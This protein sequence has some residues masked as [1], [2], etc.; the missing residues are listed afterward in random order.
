MAEAVG[1]RSLSGNILNGGPVDGGQP[2]QRN[3]RNTARLSLSLAILNAVTVWRSDKIKNNYMVIKGGVRVAAEIAFAFTA[4]LGII[5]CVARALF[6][7][8]GGLF[9]RKNIFYNGFTSAKVA[10]A[11]I[12]ASMYYALQNINLCG[13]PNIAEVEPYKRDNGCVRL[14]TREEI[15]AMETESIRKIEEWA[16]NRASELAAR[17]A[18]FGIQNLSQEEQA[19]LGGYR[20][21]HGR[22]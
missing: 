1:Q 16:D 7:L 14:F 21:E 20:R 10:F 8:A 13:S 6:G 22:V 18:Q 9:C 2:P 15:D 19:F 17:E 11:T 3:F 4:L 5:E 12:G